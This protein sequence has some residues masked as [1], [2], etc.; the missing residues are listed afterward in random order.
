[1]L[2]PSDAITLGEMDYSVKATV[3]AQWAWVGVKLPA[4]TTARGLSLPPVTMIAAKEGDNFL[5]E[6]E[7]IEVGV[8]AR[9]L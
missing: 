6:I 1:M 9:L 8:S 7:L 3:D 5:D 4:S 2:T